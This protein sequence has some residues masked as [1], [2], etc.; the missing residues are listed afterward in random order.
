MK[1]DG[2]SVSCWQHELSFSSK[3]LKD[4]N[5]A[6]DVLI[7]GGGITGIVTALRL[8]EAGIKCI[9]IEA[10]NIGFGTTGGTS[11]HLNTILET[12][13]FQVEKNFSEDI[14]RSL[15]AITSNVV[16]IIEENCSFCKD[17]ADFQQYD[18]FLLANNSSQSEDLEKYLEDGKKYHIPMQEDSSN[19]FNN[20]GKTLKLPH[21]AVFHPVKYINGLAARFLEKGGVILENCSFFDC[22]EEDNHVLITTSQ[23]EITAKYCFYA[24]HIPPGVTPHNLLC[25]PY[26]SYVAAYSVKGHFPDY[27]L[28]DMEDP[29]HYI[30]PAVIE[31]QSVVLIGGGDHKTGHPADPDEIFRHLEAY[32]SGFFELE[33]NYFKWSSQ[34]FDPADGLA[35]IGELPGS[36]RQLIA[37]GYGGNGMI[38]SHIAAQI[39]ESIVRKNHHPLQHALSPGRFKPV[40]SF[41]NFVKE[42]ADVVKELIVGVVDH[43]KIENIE[44]VKTGAGEIVRYDGKDLAIYRD[45]SGFLHG[46]HSAC[47]HLGCKVAFNKLE[48]S[49][50]CPCHGSRFSIHGELLTGP[51]TESIQPILLSADETETR[52]AGK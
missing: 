42:N 51:A 46:I 20:S 2:T 5:T 38:Y 30:R 11:A 49:W 24:T 14:A 32:G 9:L 31:G 7:V 39:I 21:Q 18:A 4:T 48:S 37:T 44:T 17:N 25:A 26:R 13:Y 28:Y 15:A 41:T 22:K 34:Y 3:Q 12:P 23:G 50:D 27:L 35:Y 6:T 36:D 19:R 47:T 8:S 16:D 43:R 45:Q 10:K 52:K 29:Y 33:K 40:A 1:R